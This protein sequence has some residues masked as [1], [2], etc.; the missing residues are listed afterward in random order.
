[1]QAKRKEG[2]ECHPHQESL[3]GGLFFIMRI[4]IAFCGSKVSQSFAK[5]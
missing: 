5:K 3:P 4:C 2:L 1:M